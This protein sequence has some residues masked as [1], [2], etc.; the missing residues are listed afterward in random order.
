MVAGI[1]PRM[2][3]RTL[4]MARFSYRA[5]DC[6]KSLKLLPGIWFPLSRAYNP[7][8]LTRH[9]MESFPMNDFVSQGSSATINSV[10]FLRFTAN[11][12]SSHSLTFVISLDSSLIPTGYKFDLF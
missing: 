8:C 2:A 6:I 9:D 3:G 4:V 12:L 7:L 1:S 11:N 10:Q 5:L